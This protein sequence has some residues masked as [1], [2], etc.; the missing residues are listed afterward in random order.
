ME[1]LKFIFLEIP[2]ISPGKPAQ[3]YLPVKYV[4]P[5]CNTFRTKPNL[6]FVFQTGGFNVMPLFLKFGLC[7]VS[8]THYEGGLSYFIV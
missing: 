6:Y 4:F 5:S 7:P 3:V 8:V 1:K 2:R